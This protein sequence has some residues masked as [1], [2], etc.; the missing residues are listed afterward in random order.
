MKS[1]V[2]MNKNFG[3]YKKFSLAHLMLN[4][5]MFA[6]LLSYG[7]AS[8][9]Y[10]T[11][12][13]ANYIQGTPPSILETADTKILNGI[14]VK[15]N[16][17]NVD[18]IIIA[19][20][21][22]QKLS[23]A[24]DT[25]PSNYSFDVDLSQLTTADI[26]DRDGDYL[27]SSNSF[28]IQS[29]TSEWKDQNNN[30]IA[31]DSTNPLGGNLCTGS[32]YKGDSSVTVT[33]QFFARTQY[34]IPTDSESRAVSKTFSVVAND[35]ICY[36]RPGVLAINTPYPDGWPDGKNNASWGS[37]IVNRS[38]PFD[39]NQ[40]V[41]QAGFI[42][43]AV[44]ASGNHFPT[45]AFP[46]ARFR[47]VPVNSISQYTYT[48]L[49]NP[50]SSLKNVPRSSVPESKSEFVFTNNVPNKGD[51]F[52]IQVTNTQ[53]NATFLYRFSIYHWVY[54]HKGNLGYISF[55]ESEKLCKNSGDRLPTRAELTNSPLAYDN[56]TNDKWYIQ[57]NGY[58]RAIGDSVMAEWG[59][60]FYYAPNNNDLRD[61][62]A[63]IS[64]SDYELLFD[65][66]FYFTQDL[67]PVVDPNG[68]VHRYSVGVA[69][70]N[71]IVEPDNAYTMCTKY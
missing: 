38:D 57:G 43:S 55:F 47:I 67:S 27:E 30:V 17:K 33:V 66:D 56:N 2:A 52:V 71:V 61:M 23:L 48:M 36:I 46:Y 25:S 12:T 20:N 26:S 35:G 37:D 70:G 42:A 13:T 53:T 62:M 69:E 4:I 14:Q 54:V 28:I 16:L 21:K 8:F 41:K 31:S 24:F 19:P 3:F 68:F 49:K 9:A 1:G 60:I 5:L 10:L 63:G 6:V 51:E 11:V 59:K 7:H 22:D 32:S 65:Y 58:K 45:T 29:I 39:P 34:G 40:F 15:L 50:N 64:S 44:D 18:P